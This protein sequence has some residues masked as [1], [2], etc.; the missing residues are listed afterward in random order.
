MIHVKYINNST[1]KFVNLNE[2][3]DENQLDIIQLTELPELKEFS[4]EN[5]VFFPKELGNLINLQYFDCSNNKLTEL[6]IEIIN[7]RNLI[8]FYYSNN[9]IVMN[10]IIQRFIDRHE[11][12]N[13]HNLYNDGQNIHTSTIQLSVKDSIM[14]LLND[15]YKKIEQ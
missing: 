15:K 6:P 13:N 7:Y 12:I 1:K 8:N 4:M 3:F 9:E 5:G 10:P 14:N 2:I 11:N